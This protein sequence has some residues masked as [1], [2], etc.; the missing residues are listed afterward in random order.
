MKTPGLIIPRPA[1]QRS[2]ALTSNEIGV[3]VPLEALFPGTEVSEATMQ[4]LLQ[5]FGRD[6]LLVACARL[7]AIVGGTGKPDTLARQQR[8]IGMICGADDLRRINEFARTR[9]PGD[10]PVVFFRGQLL[11]LMRWV[12]RFCAPTNGIESF[13]ESA[14]SRLLKAALIASK[15]WSDRVFADRFSATLPVDEARERALGAFRRGLEESMIAPYLG[16]TLG[17]GWSL[18]SEHFPRHYPDFEPEFVKA[19]GLTVEQYFTCVT[20]LALYLPFDSPTGSLFD[21]STV[22]DATAYRKKFEAYMA[23]ESQTPEELAVTL[24]DGLAERGYR[25]LRE[26]PILR[27]ANGRAIILDPVFF[28][29]KISVG[30]LFHLLPGGNANK[31]FGAFGKA[32]EDYANGILRRMYPDRPGLASRLRCGVE[33]RDSEGR[34]FE[35]DAVLDYV[36]QAVVFEQKA[37]W[38]RDEVVLGDIE[39]WIEQIRSRY[40]IS[41]VQ[42]GGK[43]ERPKGVAQLAQ[44]V[45]RIIDRNGG[46]AQPIFEEVSVIHPVLLVHDTRL[47]APAYGTFLDAEFRRLFGSVPKDKR[48]MPMVIMTIDDLENLES[49]VAEF[50]MQQLLADYAAAQPEG[51][52]S[53]HNFMVHDERYAEKVK[54]SA[55]LVADARRL[56]QLAQREL[57]P[58]SPDLDWDEAN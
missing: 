40:G 28:S 17:R 51:L 12:A 18:F 20:G 48:V 15:F 53:L 10:V 4:E 11:E 7:N 9:P 41:S 23:S 19:T 33:A 8:A 34:D 36:P 35:I 25:D 45:R 46:A 26:R 27:L 5:P 44:I 16:T 6:A 58:N 22:A 43:K 30:P 54:V 14:K 57:F 56:I 3:Y 13:D 50:G 37:A 55:Q 38:L 24:W 29:E 32:F 47:N 42:M 31:I 2:A 21:A 49:S 1:R 52:V 39:V